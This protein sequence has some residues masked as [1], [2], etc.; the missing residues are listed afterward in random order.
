MLKRPLTPTRPRRTVNTPAPAFVATTFVE[1]QIEFLPAWLF[2]QTLHDL[3]QGPRIHP[4]TGQEICKVLGL[5][6]FEQIIQLR[7]GVELLPRTGPVFDRRM[8]GVQGAELLPLPC[9]WP[10][11]GLFF[12]PLY[13]LF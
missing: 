5:L 13:L 9:V 8:L 6:P 4:V 7:N 10:S 1:G 11:F 2:L 12:Q 3:A